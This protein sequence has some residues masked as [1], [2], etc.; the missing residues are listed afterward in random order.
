MG[1]R[2]VFTF[3]SMDVKKDYNEEV[4]QTEPDGTTELL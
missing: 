2:R 3:I 4:P 1:R